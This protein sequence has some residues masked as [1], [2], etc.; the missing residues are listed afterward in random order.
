MQGDKLVSMKKLASIIFTILF[1]LTLI[2][3]KSIFAAN[4]CNIVVLNSP[5]SWDDKIEVQITG[6]KPDTRFQ[7]GSTIGVS[8]PFNL[9]SAMSDSNGDIT[10]RLN[11]SNNLAGTHTLRVFRGASIISPFCLTTFQVI[12]PSTAPGCQPPGTPGAPGTPTYPEECTESYGSGIKTAF[13][14]FPIEPAQLVNYLIPR[15]ISVGIGFAFM[16][17]LY[18][19]FVL[20]T[21]AGNPE[22]TKK[23]QE[24]ITSAVIGLLFII[25]SVFLLK[26]I[27]FDILQISGF[28]SP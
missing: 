22:N 6:L 18:G 9:A 24:I 3:P 26:V 12:D 14:C 8:W 20:I 17:M 28:A 21:S 16:F 2:S 10:I 4:N 5:V 15:G 19:A 25:F 13:G 27:G 11:H 1:I 7:I 23:G